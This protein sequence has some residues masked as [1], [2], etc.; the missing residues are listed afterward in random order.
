MKKKVSFFVVSIIVIIS[1][2]ALIKFNSASGT[3]EEAINASDPNKINLI[4]EEKTDKGSIVFYNRLGYDE[5]STAFIKKDIG[6][7]KTLYDGVQE[8][9]SK[10]SKKIGITHSYF[11]AIEKTS[12]PIYFGIIGDSNI[13]Q[14]KVIEKK[15]NIEGQAKIIN[16]K[17][18]RIWLVYMSKFEGSDFEII[19]LSKDGK[20]LT[21]IDG[22]ISPRSAEEKPLESNYK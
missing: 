5:L 3:I 15:R 16:A 20:E 13:S 1:L 21:R 8:D 14:V 17:G 12:L 6:G 9:I 19:G 2:F 4:H 11:P 7:Y 22:N 18:T 10:V